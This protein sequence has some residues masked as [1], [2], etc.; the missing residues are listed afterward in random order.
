M[1]WRLL[2]TLA[3]SPG[4]VVPTERLLRRG[5]GADGDATADDLRVFI[6][7]LRRKL[8]DDA[9]RPRYIETVRGM[10][11]RLRVD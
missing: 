1:E 2:E 3:G 9:K 10:G 7:R 11:Y 8:G 4:W 5:W 6:G